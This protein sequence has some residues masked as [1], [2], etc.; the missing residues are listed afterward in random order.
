MACPL[1]VWLMPTPHWHFPLNGKFHDIKREL[2]WQL[3]LIYWSFYRPN[4]TPKIIT[5]ERR[6]LILVI[7]NYLEIDSIVWYFLVELKARCWF[8]RFFLDGSLVLILKTRCSAQKWPKKTEKKKNRFGWKCMRAFKKDVLFLY[9][10]V[11]CPS[12]IRHF[13]ETI[14]TS[15]L[16]LLLYKILYILLLIVYYIWLIY[17]GLK[18]RPS[19]VKSIMKIWIMFKTL[20]R[21]SGSNISKY[22]MWTLFI[23]SNKLRVFP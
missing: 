10:L 13:L 12:H 5:C 17:P 19:L 22:I 18:S 6:R 20:F 15:L 9:L 7:W 11:L 4:I 23:F 8:V 14:Y 2:I 16:F 1:G 3:K 21:K